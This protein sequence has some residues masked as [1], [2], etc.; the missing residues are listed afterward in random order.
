[1]CEMTKI[2]FGTDGWRGV[3]SDDFTFANVRRV[4]QAVSDYY[5]LRAAGKK[6]AIAIGYDYRFLS[7][8]YAQIMA[9]VFANNGIDVVLS[10]QAVP[11]P[12]LSYAVKKLGLRAGIMI[13]ASHNPGE[14]NGIKIKTDAGGAAGADITGEVEKLLDDPAAHVDRPL[15][16]ID[17][18]DMTAD[19]VRFLR[20]YVDLKKFKNAKYRVLV[21]PMHGSGRDFLTRV[22][23][24]TSIKLEFTRLDHNPS[25][26][27]LRPEPI[28]ENLQATIAKIKKGKY[29]LC[30]VLDG[31]ADRIAAITG[32][33]EFVSPQ[34][35]LGLLMLHL[36]QDRKMSGAVVTTY[37][38]TN[39]IAKAAADLGMK[40]YETPV[41]FKYISELMVKENILV[42]GEEA[43]GMGFK[44][45]VPERDGSLAG[46]L[47]LEMMVMRKKTFTQILK[48]MEKKYG[49]YYYLREFVKLQALG[50]FTMDSVAAVKQVL[51]T[52]V[53]KVNATDGVKLILTD[54]SWLMLRASGTEPMVRIY[55]ES[56]S[57]KRT[58]D[59]LAFGRNLILKNAV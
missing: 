15:G 2:K 16:M 21:D 35:I 19:Y 14:Y 36:N 11:T 40:M 32:D 54:G 47:L 12:T 33:G 51:G 50:S 44:D 41:G 1:M 13:T 39:L 5:N 17:T 48:D 3:I 57:L 59:M 53:A 45:Y 22:L 7:D 29:D 34:K 20:S 28:P 27:G 38:G 18:V 55:A 9:E 52:D 8:R 23:K 30:L 24:G 26:E 49:R 6:V 58:K 42:G 37:C 4:G 31:D 43:G 46:L 25:F 10:D 56:L